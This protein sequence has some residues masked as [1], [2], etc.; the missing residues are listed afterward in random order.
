MGDIFIG[1]RIYWPE[2]MFGYLGR[3][4]SCGV[5][6][7]IIVLFIQG[8]SAAEQITKNHAKKSY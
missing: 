6:V 4:L 8:K 5:F 2:I 1:I 7:Y 3:V